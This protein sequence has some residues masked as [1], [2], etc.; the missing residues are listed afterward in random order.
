M[1]QA[2]IG[3]QLSG[4][5]TS[6]LSGSNGRSELL[7]FGFIAVYATAMSYFAVLKHNAFLSYWFDLGIYAQEFWLKM[8]GAPSILFEHRP[9][10]F[11]LLP[12]YSLFPRPETLLVIQSVILGLA[13]LPLYWFAR[14][15]L[16]SPLA[17]VVFAG[18]LLLYPP[19]HGVNTFDFHVEAF[20]VPF[21]MFAL[22]YLHR[23]R[24]YRYFLFTGLLLLTMVEASLLVGAM[25]LYALWIYRQR[26]ISFRRESSLTISLSWTL[27]PRIAL[28]TL[29]MAGIAYGIAWFSGAA[30]ALLNSLIPPAVV[31]PLLSDLATKLTYV[32][33]VFGPLGFLAFL[34]PMPLLMAVPWWG[35]SFTSSFPE[36][37]SIYFQYGAFVTPFV[38]FAGVLGAKNLALPGGTIGIASARRGLV[39]IVVTSLLF[40]QWLSPLAQPWPIMDTRRQTIHQIIV[41]IPKESSVLTQNDLYPHLTG[42]F[43]LYGSISTSDI[44][45]YIL[46]D[47]R[48]YWFQAWPPSEPIAVM[49]QRLLQGARYGVLA[50]FD[51][52][53]LYQLGYEGSPIV[54]DEISR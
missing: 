42:R 10:L 50:E 13:A 11:G 23:G 26:W 32:V 49:L 4:R 2:R 1:V 12:V 18:A 7:V 36:M 47:T 38:F 29:L 52:I 28:A 24:W 48:S 37:I 33:Q 39:L 51:G 3:S 25:G 6:Y 22:Y 53:Y 41:L 14:D 8:Q 54:M 20:L 35:Y 45:E 44:T 19:L 21:F 9:I 31:G 30:P 17:G 40:F 34:S 5:V 16:K 46:V 27:Q 15:E 43:R